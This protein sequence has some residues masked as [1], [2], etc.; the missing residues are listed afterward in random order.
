MPGKWLGDVQMKKYKEIRKQYRQEIAANKMGISV[1]TARR[2]ERRE[3]LPSQKGQRT[4]RTRKDPF[5]AYW[6]SE[7][8]PLLRQE[9]GLLATT[10]LEEMQRLHPGEVEPG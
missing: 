1:R 2:W 7:I 5:A 10:V 9:P 8:L 4:W 6:Q 3:T